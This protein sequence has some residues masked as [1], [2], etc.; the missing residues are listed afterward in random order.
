[1]TIVSNI[2]T[3][4][5]FSGQLWSSFG[6][7]NNKKKKKKENK[8]KKTKTKTKILWNGKAFH[9]GNR[10]NNR[11]SITE[12]MTTT[13]T[14]DDDENNLN[15]NN[16]NLNSNN[17]NLNSNSNS[18]LFHKHDFDYSLQKSKFVNDETKSICLKYSKYQSSIFTSLWYTMTDELRYITLPITTTTT[19]TDTVALDNDNDNDNDTERRRRSRRC[20]NKNILIGLGSM[21]WSGGILNC[22]PFVLWRT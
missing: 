7:N 11:F 5:L 17:S 13:A 10:G 14:D 20:I 2:M 1:M 22:S 18:L 3:H 6:I 19:T 21:S 16:S 12:H 8:M 9:P 15:S 4:T